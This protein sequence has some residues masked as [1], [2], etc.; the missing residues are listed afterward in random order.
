ML[1]RNLWERCGKDINKK[2]V[3]DMLGLENPNSALNSP[4]KLWSQLAG[5]DSYARFSSVASSLLCVLEVDSPTRVPNIPGIPS[6]HYPLHIVPKDQSELGH[7]TDGFYVSLPYQLS[8]CVFGAS[9]PFD[10]TTDRVYQSRMGLRF[11]TSILLTLC[12]D[13]SSPVSFSPLANSTPTQLHHQHRMSVDRSLFA[14]TTAY[15]STLS[16]GVGSLD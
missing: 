10:N 9:R 5:T 12:S 11:L 2:F 16:G 7:P 1:Y 8:D 15:R 6:N 3:L 13:Q 14:S 4:R